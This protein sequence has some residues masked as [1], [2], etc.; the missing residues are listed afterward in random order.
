MDNEQLY[1]QAEQAINKLFF[2]VSV[3]KEVTIQ[4]LQGLIS[5]IHIMLDSLTEDAGG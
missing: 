4:N 3:S 1:K 2:D 5:E